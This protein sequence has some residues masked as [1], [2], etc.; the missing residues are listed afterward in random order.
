MSQLLQHKANLYIDGQWF[1]FASGDQEPIINPAT[2]EVIGHA[3]IAKKQDA[4]LAIDAA[5]RAF[6]SGVWPGLSAKTRADKIKE[7]LNYLNSRRDAIIEL[8]IAETG[9]TRAVTETIQFGFP[10]KHAERS[11]QLAPVLDELSGVNPE[12]VPLGE[13]SVLGTGTRVR[14]PAGVVVAITPYNFPYLMNVGKVVQSLLAG[15]TVVLKPSP[16]TPLQAF[17]LAEAIDA[18]DLPAGTFN[19]VTGDAEI[20][21]A[22]T[23]H[24]KVDLISFTGSDKVGAAIQAQA[25]PTLKRSLMELGGKSPLIVRQDADLDAAVRTS[26]GS[27]TI[28]AGQGCALTT[29]HL[30]HNSIREEYLAK[31]SAMAST[32]KLGNPAD[33]S[34]QMGPLIRETA[35]QRA[36]SYVQIALDEG[37]KLVSGGCRPKSLDHGFF[38][39]PTLFDGVSNEMRIAREEVFGPIAVVVGFDSDEQAIAMAND[40]EF[41]LGGGVFS[42][43]VGKAYEMA[44]QI[45][46]GTVAINGGAGTM[47]SDAPFGGIKR[48]GYGKEYGLEGM[49]EFTYQK[50]ITFRGA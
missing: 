9:A 1:P 48:S 50:L 15:C 38:F 32:I 37:A 8:I 40:S 2:E 21:E 27:F 28:H 41:G 44:M 3:P 30:V 42:G 45:R 10:M 11:V 17:L 6:D 26:L 33:A 13:S 43:D 18:V 25:A 29:R 49:L 7:L 12:V 35:R 14:M 5:R 39:Q 46:S 36:E 20:G 24:P 16:Y 19:L 23:S 47:L 22:L 4:E 31:L 34:V